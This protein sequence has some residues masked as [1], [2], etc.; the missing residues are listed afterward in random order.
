LLPRTGAPFAVRL[1]PPELKGKPIQLVAEAGP[2]WVE[3][4]LLVV[5]SLRAL[6][7]AV[8]S[9]SV[10][11]EGF[12]LGRLVLFAGSGF[13]AGAH[14][15]R[16]RLVVLAAEEVAVNEAMK[17]DQPTAISR[18]R[19]RRQDACRRARELPVKVLSVAPIRIHS[20]SL[21][22]LLVGVRPRMASMSHSQ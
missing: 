11:E 16:A 3:V 18:Q 12:H 14:R 13:R 19:G 22:L 5:P 15:C 10:E 17:A 2:R 9:V 8:R 21:S 4:T 1:N 7:A 6:F 20:S